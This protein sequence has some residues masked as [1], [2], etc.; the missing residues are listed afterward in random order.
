MAWA[1]RNMASGAFLSPDGTPEKSQYSTFVHNNFAAFEG[2]MNVTSGVYYNPTDKTSYWYWG[3]NYYMLSNPN[4]LHS[5]AKPGY[6]LCSDVTTECNTSFAFAVFPPWQDDELLV[7]VAHAEHLEFADGDAVRKA[8]GKRL[9]EQILDP[10][11]D[12]YLG[13]GGYYYQPLSMLTGSVGPYS[14]GFN[15]TSN[16]FFQT[17]ADIKA[18]TVPGYFSQSVTGCTGTCGTGTQGVFNYYSYDPVFGY[19][20]LRLGATAMISDVVDATS[21]GTFTG[22]AARAW[23]VANV[24]SVGQSLQNDNPMWA[25]APLNQSSGPS[26]F[27]PCDLN[28]DNLVN[29]IDIQM[30]ISQSLGTSACSNGDVNNDGQCNVMDIQRVINASMGQACVTQ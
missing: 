14:A 29:L 11:Y 12:H 15:G 9:V 17:W 19:T 5:I 18:A 1:L 4:P 13:G 6:H 7:C 21:D 20:L 16:E 30:N 3:R 2:A 24:P 8:L 23:M 10:S 28:Q 27:S 25:F 22:T 26:S